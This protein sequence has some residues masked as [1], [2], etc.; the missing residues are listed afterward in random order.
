[1]RP[2][3]WLVPNINQTQTTPT[4]ANAERLKLLFFV[5][6]EPDKT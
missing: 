3:C 4:G 5:M 2:I 1:M 6:V